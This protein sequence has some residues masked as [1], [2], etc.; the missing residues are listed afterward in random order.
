[1][2]EQKIS[3]EEQKERE[4]KEPEEEYSFLQ[5]VIK[6]ELGAKKLRSGIL[7]MI[8]LGSVFGIV[9]CFS[10]Q[11]SKPWIENKL[12]GDPEQ[13]T[14]PRDEEE[15][16]EEEDGAEADAEGEGGG[17]DA[18]E[19]GD[20]T[21][22]STA[23]PAERPVLDA[24][25]YRQMLQSLKEVAKDSADS[26]VEIT[27]LS[28]GDDWEEDLN[29]SRH[30]VSGI[31]VADNGQELLVLG[32][33][34]PVK[35]AESIRV[36]FAGGDRYEAAVKASDVNLGLSVYAVPRASITEETWTK[37][38]TAVLGNSNLAAAGD[39]AIVLGKPFGYANAYAYGVI[40]VDKADV[41][42]LDG[43]YEVVYTDISGSEGASGV[44]VN[45]RGE[46]IAVV[47]QELL[48]EDGRGQIA[49]YGISDIK[50]VIERLSNGQDV[51][52]IGIYG[53]NVTEDLE[54]QGLP[55]GIYVKE[56]ET[57]SPA[58][59]AGIQNGDI[60]TVMDDTEI[61]DIEGYHAILMKKNQGERISFKG[62][63]QGT[64]GEY[65]DIDFSVTVGAKK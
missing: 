56:V 50:D 22:E 54:G 55:K 38:D 24:E 28:E 12:G 36:T 34:C 19:S 11:V 30:S 26:I 39:T 64:G 37:I 7:H 63:R 29:G 47:N 59:A 23:A 15:D 62:C 31:I 13:V 48:E 41:T 60:I 46:V 1:M 3:E 52:Y 43:Q 58:M 10:F 17:G 5:E 32:R 25:S 53:I 57:D 4:Q 49:G 65:V 35:N 44:L 61:F 16:G 45:M 21:Q 6:D 2:D 33:I 20:D 18:Q 9:A 14:I 27:G 42:F 51:P 8:A 40:S